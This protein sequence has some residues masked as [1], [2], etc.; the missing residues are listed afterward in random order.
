MKI[1][2]LFFTISVCAIAQDFGYEYYNLIEFRSLGLSYS[3][4]D[5]KGQA[6]NA[7]SRS[8]QISF[9]SNLPMIEYRQLNT[10]LSLGYQNYV[11]NGS[12]KNVYS[13]FAQQGNDY[14]LFGNDEHASLLLPL[15][16]SANYIRAQGLSPVIKNFDVGSVGLGT[17]IKYRSFSRS[18]GIQLY[19]GA[20]LH[21]STVGFSTEYGTQ[22]SFQSEVLVMLPS[23]LMDGIIFGYR[24]EEQRWNMND[25]SFN[26][27]RLYHGPFLGIL[28]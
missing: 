15:F 22:T 4:Q 21:Y 5:F 19:A 10:R 24:F 13:V 6:T 28:F 16:A 20:A 17:G 18:F 23:V 14:P 9:S 7:L 3:L 26:Y 25:N 11:L 27:Q 8:S 12:E 2:F 1:F